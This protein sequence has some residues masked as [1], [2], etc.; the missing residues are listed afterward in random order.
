MTED[1]TESAA[2]TQREAPPAVID[3]ENVEASIRSQGVRWEGTNDGQLRSEHWSDDIMLNLSCMS[4][5]D[6]DASVSAYFDG[7]TARDLATTL[8]ENNAET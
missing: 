2:H 5:S 6:A 3:T 1:G 7:D 8:R 4:D